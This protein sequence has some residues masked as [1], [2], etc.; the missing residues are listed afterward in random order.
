MATKMSEVIL[1]WVD[2]G[3]DIEKFHIVGHSLGA[4]MAGLIGRNAHRKS[5]GETQIIRITGLD[6]AFPAFY[7]PIGATPINKHD[8][9]FVD[10]IHTDAW[11]YGAPKSTGTVDFWPNGGKTLQPGCPRRN[12]KPLSENGKTLPLFIASRFFFKFY[13]LLL[14]FPVFLLFLQFP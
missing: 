12:Y 9:V 1:D 6:P 11:I 4:Q 14:I 3:L 5:E 13:F 7:P 10:I 8:A 2:E